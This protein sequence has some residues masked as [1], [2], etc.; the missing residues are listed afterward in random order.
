M[1]NYEKYVIICNLL[2]GLLSIFIAINSAYVINYKPKVGSYHIYL[3]IAFGILLVLFSIWAVVN[4]IIFLIKKKERK[5]I[6][7]PFNI[8]NN[9]LFSLL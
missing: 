3:C 9:R 7:L 2:P 5:I 8:C 6:I 4:C 1:K